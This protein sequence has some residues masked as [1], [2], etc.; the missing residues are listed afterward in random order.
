MEFVAKPFVVLDL[1]IR[2]DAVVSTVVAEVSPVV[3]V[4]PIAADIDHPL[5][6][7]YPRACGPVD[8]ASAGQ[9]SG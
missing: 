8:S 4:E 2:Q 6:E 5:I 1:R 7:C 3:V 9:H